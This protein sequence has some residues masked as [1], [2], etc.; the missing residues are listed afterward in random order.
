[1]AQCSMCPKVTVGKNRAWR[2]VCGR[3][4]CGHYRQCDCGLHA[5]WAVKSCNACG[6]GPV[7]ADVDLCA[8]CQ[9]SRV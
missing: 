8:T 3:V 4:H 9:A 2:C 7:Q 6:G 1:M 5:P